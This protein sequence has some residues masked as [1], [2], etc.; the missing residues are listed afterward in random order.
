MVFSSLLFIW[1]FLPIVFIGYYFF[2]DIQYRNVFL[3]VCS[4]LFYAWGEPVYILLMFFSI[5]MNWGIGICIEKTDR[6]KNI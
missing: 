6:L 3:L 2:S 1:I 4:L 5:L